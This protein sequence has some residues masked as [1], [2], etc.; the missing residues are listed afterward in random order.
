[1]YFVCIWLLKISGGDWVERIRDCFVFC[2]FSVSS[3]V[4]MVVTAEKVS[5]E[6]GA[7][8]GQKV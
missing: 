5:L 3:Q 4:V 1:M 6:P 2:F 7:C 8:R